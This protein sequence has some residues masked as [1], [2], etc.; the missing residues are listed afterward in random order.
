MKKLKYCVYVLY[1]L[2]DRKLYIG[3]TAD[4]NQRLTDHIR[5]FAKAT[6]FRRPFILIHCEYYLSKKDAMRRER[7]FKTSDGKR[8]LKIMLKDAFE[9]MKG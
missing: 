3:F 1:S 8:A 6:K 2:K 4:L 9:N 5:G 7:Y